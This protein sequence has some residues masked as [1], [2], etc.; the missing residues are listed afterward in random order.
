VANQYT[1]ITTGGLSDNTV[2]TMYD[3]SLGMVYRETPMFRAWADKRPEQVNG[4]G[5]TIQLQKQ[6]FFDA[7]SVTAAKTPLNEEMDVDSTKL[8]A[9]LPINLTVNEYG[10]AVTRTKKLKYFSFA[11]IDSIA[12]RS[13][14]AHLADVMDELFQD[15]MVTGT[16]ILRAQ[17]RASTNLIQTTDLL[18]AQDVRKAHTWLN[19]NKVPEWGGG[20]Y[21]GAIHPHVLHDLREETGSG[22]WRVPNE[23]GTN[24]SNIWTGEFGE[25]E[26]VR[27]VTN[28]RTRTALDGVSSGKVYRTFILGREAIAEKVVEEPNTV[29][30]P[31]T[32]KLQRFRTIG[33]Y[34]VLGWALYRDESLV[35]IHSA[36]SVPTLQTGTP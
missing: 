10:F 19:A 17:N 9:T 20:F 14:G 22:S 21:A 3:F 2:K 18:R 4:P 11:D 27:F 16:Q 28:T 30:G 7:A 13:V 25:F 23:Y 26:G 1:S 12:I 32:D 6:Q 31:V 36:S 34:G 33:W 5:Q 29:I 35:T 8:P 24:Q 15:V